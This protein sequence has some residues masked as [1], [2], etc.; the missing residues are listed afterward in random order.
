MTVIP[1]TTARKEHPF[2]GWVLWG[3]SA[4]LLICAIGLGFSYWSSSGT[5]RITVGNES[6]VIGNVTGNVGD[7][8]VV[9]GSTDDKGNTVLNTPM[10]VGSGAHTDGGSIAIGANA[11]AA[12]GN[13]NNIILI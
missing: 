7:K 9:I 12:Q 2:W 1:K 4:V 3:S 13:C 6:V 8:S 11:G 10:A 5:G